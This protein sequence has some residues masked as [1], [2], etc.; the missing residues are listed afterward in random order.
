MFQA[1][2]ERARGIISQEYR[3]H[4]RKS[5]SDCGWITSQTAAAARVQ[6]APASVLV[7]VVLHERAHAVKCV[8]R[9]LALVHVPVG[10]AQPAL[11]GH[12][13]VRPF[14]LVAI[15]ISRGRDTKAVAVAG[16]PAANVPLAVKRREN[17][18]PVPP[19]VSPL[20]AIH[21]AARTNKL[22]KPCNHLIPHPPA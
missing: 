1:D 7:T 10:G 2:G 4:G 15:A 9:P 5:E 21:I 20:P 13:P 6:D 17:A 3:P 16:M 18:A 22:T 12:A 8:I 19:A 11:S 14:A